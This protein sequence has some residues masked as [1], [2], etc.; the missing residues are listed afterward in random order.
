LVE[1]HEVG[2]DDWTTLPD[3]NGHRSPATGVW[4]E[5]DWETLHPFL[6]HYIAAAGCARSG[7]T[8]TWN[9]ASGSSGGFQS[10]DV[11]LKTFRRARLSPP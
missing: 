11:D 8:G 2:H 9:A 6:D 4:C 7:A 5:D 3:A 1:A 10:W